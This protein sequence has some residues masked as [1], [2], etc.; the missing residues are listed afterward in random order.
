MNIDFNL[1]NFHFL[2]PEWF[3][4]LI[5]LA[6]LALLLL[7]RKLLSRNWQSVIDPKLMPYVLIGKA[8]KQ[9]YWPV[10]LLTVAGVMT[11]IAQAGPVWQRL[12][13][14]VYK[15][16][17]AMVIA[18]DLS[19]SMDAE[20]I[21]PSRL[22]RAQY[23]LRDLL[24][25][26]HEG[27]TALVVY[28]NAAFTVTP[29]TDDTN[30]IATMIPSLST[31]MLPAQG[32]NTEAA[33]TKSVELLKNA[34]VKDGDI[35]LITDD[36]DISSDIFSS[37]H[38]Q[39]YRV[40]ILGIGTTDGAPIARSNG[41]FIKDNQ[42]G[43]VIS[44]LDASRLAEAARHGGGRYSNLATDERDIKY[45]LDAASVN[46]LQGNNKLTEMKT[47]T[48]H[49]Q[50]PWLLWLVIPLA[51]LAFRKG[52]V[53]VLLLFILPLPQPAQAISW[54]ELWKNNNQRAA[55][56]LAQN[57][58]QTA[59]ELFK[60]P[61]WQAAAHYR[62]GNF[63]QAVQALADINHTDAHYNRGN[64]LA[65][66]GKINEAINA[67]DEAL[68]LDPKNEDAAY[69]KEQLLKQQQQQKNNNKQDSSG[70]NQSGDQNQDNSGDPQSGQDQSGDQSGDNT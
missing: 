60:D 18:L 39:G 23:K 42:G 51:A 34:G 16:Q 66:L 41:D 21:K 70:K 13:Q 45:L 29:L 6:I 35:L 36:I 43:I 62:A 30:T 25:L 55:D 9:S 12:P 68:K 46:R 50:G 64:A 27:Q 11:I 53:A 49:E 63:D 56:E 17:S 24:A 8:G 19:S 48:W 67:Y 2:R 52:Y 44:K 57:N 59:A 32:N 40:S 10:I 15:Q 14:P 65:K 61:Q 1:A 54:D 33:L 58:P 31:N 3:Y 28:A 37:V 4:A 22:Q 5:P 7:R 69:N 47:D 20:D 26:R 38:Q